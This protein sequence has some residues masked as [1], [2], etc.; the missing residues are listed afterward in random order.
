M[1]TKIVSGGGTGTH[2]IDLAH[3]PFTE[4]QAGSYVFMDADY[5][6]IRSRGGDVLPF[7]CSLYMFSNVRSTC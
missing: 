4:I 3:E 6:R 5:A 7:E 1:E 2:A